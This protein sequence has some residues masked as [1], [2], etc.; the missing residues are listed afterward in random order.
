MSPGDIVVAA[1]SGAVERKVRPAVVV[2]S[3]TY[4]VE[5]PDVIVGMLTTRMP[6]PL[7]STDY[8]LQDWHSGGLRAPSCF[9][10]YLLTVHR[11][12]TTVIGH[13]SWRDWVEVRSGVRTALAE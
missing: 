7:A 12:Q 13:L 1:L 5:R 8:V 3:E 9:R 4:L 6:A 2:A 10:A 11:S